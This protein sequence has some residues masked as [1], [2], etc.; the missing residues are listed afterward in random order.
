MINLKLMASL[1]LENLTN[2]MSEKEI[3]C[4]FVYKDFK[5]FWYY[6]NKIYICNIF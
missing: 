6:M 2:I 5:F 4:K 1:L 3:N